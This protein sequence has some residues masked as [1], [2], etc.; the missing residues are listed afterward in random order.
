M[1]V[2]LTFKL[3]NIVFSFLMWLDKINVREDYLAACNDTD[4]SEKIMGRMGQCLDF[5]TL[6]SSYSLIF[7]F[8]IWLIKH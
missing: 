7:S 5:N 8:I 6:P 4:K 2:S 1:M 3:L